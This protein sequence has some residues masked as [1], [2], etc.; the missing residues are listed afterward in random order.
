MTKDTHRHGFPKCLLSAASIGQ[1]SRFDREWVSRKSI[2][3]CMFCIIENTCSS[4]K[5]DKP[6]IKVLLF[7]YELWERYSKAMRSLKQACEIK[8]QQER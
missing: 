7:C 2:E 3:V 6:L 1:L 4:R 5:N 8:A